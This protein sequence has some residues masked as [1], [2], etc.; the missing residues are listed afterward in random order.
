M[1]SAAFKQEYVVD[2]ENNVVKFE[3]ID[4]L[5]VAKDVYPYIVRISDITDSEDVV[6][7]TAVTYQFETY[8]G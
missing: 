5:R 7:D 6:L 4:D 8:C 2:D 3:L 1:L